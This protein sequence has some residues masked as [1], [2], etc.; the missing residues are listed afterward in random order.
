MAYR[1]L[2]DREQASGL[3][4]TAV[5]QEFRVGRY[6]RYATRMSGK[7]QVVA[8]DFSPRAQDPRR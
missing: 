1:T 6:A 4:S 2:L 5:D 3:S 7:P 8:S